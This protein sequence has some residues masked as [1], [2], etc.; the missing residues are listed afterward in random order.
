MY[1]Y[2]SRRNP[3]LQITESK[4]KKAQNSKEPCHQLST[5]SICHIP[6]QSWEDYMV[7]GKEKRTCIQFRILHLKFLARKAGLYA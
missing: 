3:K 5:E 7:D 4:I 2:S 1:L 6:G